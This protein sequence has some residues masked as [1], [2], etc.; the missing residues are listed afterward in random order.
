MSEQLLRCPANWL[1]GTLEPTGPDGLIASVD[2]GST[3]KTTDEDYWDGDVPWLT[4]KEIT[5]SS[6]SLYVSQTD[7]TI[8]EAG[9]A[10]CSARLLPPGTVML[11]KRAPVGAVAVNTVP[12]ATN[13]GFLN[14][15]CGRM[16]R[17][18]YLAIWLK[19]NRAYLDMVAN[20]STYPE[21]YKSD[22]F[23]FEIQVPDIAKQEAIVDAVFALEY[24]IMQGTPLEQSCPELA[25]IPSINRDTQKLREV[26]MNLILLLLS[27]QLD[28]AHVK[29]RFSS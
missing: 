20:G 2:T 19:A 24:I 7:R 13:Q 12:M 27:G 22:L 23:E 25:R 28:P 11:T 15:R 9:L 29:T 14:F 8:T 4:P 1:R 10:S 16:L 26:S 21:L 3:P 6:F 5:R 17:P 18:L